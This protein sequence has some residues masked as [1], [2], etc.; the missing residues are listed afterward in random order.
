MLHGT[1]IEMPKPRKSRAMLRPI[2]ADDVTPF[3]FFAATAARSLLT[4]DSTE[5]LMNLEDL[6]IRTGV[7]YQGQ[8]YGFTLKPEWATAVWDK[9]R[10]VD[11]PLARCRIITVNQRDFVLPVYG[12][13]SR[14]A[15]SRWGGVLGVWATSETADLSQSKFQSQPSAARVNFSCSRL[16]VQ[17]PPMSRD[18]FADT[19]LIMPLLDY[20]AES[21]IRFQ[22]EQAMIQGI[23]AG[24]SGVVVPGS[25]LPAAGV[26]QIAKDS[27][28][29]SGT[30]SETNITNMWK[31]LYGPCKRNAIWSCTDATLGSIDEVASAANWP[32]AIYLPQGVA[33]N[34][35]P[36]IKG[37][38]CIVNENCSA[39]GTPADLVL[40]DWS[41]YHLCVRRVT[42]NDLSTLSFDISLPRDEG[43]TGIIA[44]PEGVMERS[45]SED[46]FF[47]SDEVAVRL[48]LRGDGRSIW[49]STLTTTDGSTV[50]WA[51]TIAQR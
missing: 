32:S 43:H 34:E 36:L 2:A 39:I 11:G 49:P 18:L 9:A 20:S 3:G 42:K 15:G 46:V 5:R 28:Q 31:S 27:G 38:P 51:V 41:Q 47:L 23:I 4:F 29:S 12:E 6:Q 22:L 16:I 8:D 48:K 33:G 45:Y 13:S 19:D 50:G 26:V 10:T 25:G 21:E 44:L 30:I 1:T 40:A 7:G 14:A 24:P 17:F 35:F 37:R